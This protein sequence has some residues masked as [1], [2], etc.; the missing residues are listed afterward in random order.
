MNCIPDIMHTLHLGVYQWAF[1]S[2]LYYLIHEYLPGT[3][4]QKLDRV[5][6]SIV[7]GYKVH[8]KPGMTKFN[9]IRP[10]MYENKPFPKLRGKAAELRHFAGPL[11]H[12]CR[13]LL[14][15]THTVHK[16]IVVFLEH[17]C[18]AERLLDIHRAKSAPP[19]V[20][21]GFKSPV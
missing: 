8:S 9:E 14:P 17:C 6:T 13:A 2:I 7:A 3:E 15:L 1:G 12:A 10:S 4:K 20:A 16:L 18:V 5:W 11:L 21:V 19:A